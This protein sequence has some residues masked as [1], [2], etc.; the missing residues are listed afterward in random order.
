MKRYNIAEVTIWALA[1]L[2]TLHSTNCLGIEEI[3]NFESQPSI[4]LVTDGNGYHG[5]VEEGD[6]LVNVTPA[7][8]IEKT[9][10]HELLCNILILHDGL[11]DDESPFQVHLLDQVKGTAELHLKAPLNCEEKKSYQ[12]D[13]QA[14]SCTG[15]YSESVGVHVLVEDVNEFAPKWKIRSNEKSSESEP[16]HTLATNVAIEEGQLLEEVIRVEATDEDCS[17]H[18][19]D[20]CG[21][22]IESQNQP[23]TIS[24]EGVIKNTIPLNY[25]VS[26]SYI[27]SVVAFD[28]GQKRSEPLL[29]TVEVKKACSTGWTGLPRLISYVPGT[30]PQ[31]LFGD[32]SL[33]IC[34]KTSCEPE[35][36]EAE[37]TLE[38]S[39][40]GKGCDRDTYNLA[41]QRQLC[42]ASDLAIDLLPD[43][44]HPGSEWASAFLRDQGQ[45]SDS[46]MARFNGETG[47]NIPE[48][49]IASDAFPTHKFTI[50]SWMRHRHNKG[51]DKHTKE[52]ILC[53]ADDH[54]KNRHHLALFVRNCKLVLL[55]R[56][57]YQEG[58]ENTFRPAEWRWRLPQ[59]CDDEWH[60]YAVNVN[61]PVV[62]L[63]VDGEE[64][65]DKKD[66]PEII[67]D[68]P[69]H[70]ADD[71]TTKVT[72]GACW[73]G[74]ENRY[75]HEFS[76]YLA[77]LSYL[78]N[79]VEH[80]EVLRCLHQCAESLQVPAA[81]NALASGTEMTSDA[82]GSRVILTA[83]G[84]G[85]DKLSDLVHQVAYLNTRE[86]P[87]PGKRILQLATTLH[88]R[89]GRTIHLENELMDV[90]V[91]PVPEPVVHISGTSDISREY[92]DFKLGVRIFADVHIV[93]T[94]GSPTGNGEPVNGI[95]NRLDHCSITVSPPLNPDHEAI[96]VPDDLLRQLAVLGKVSADGVE[97]S[98]AEMIYNY[99][100]VLRQVTYSNKKPAYYLNRQ[101]RITCSEL[102][103]RFVSNEY[104]QTLT[105]IHPQLPAV[106][107]ASSAIE[108]SVEMTDKVSKISVQVQPK[109]SHLKMG[110]HG[111]EQPAFS[112]GKNDNFLT[113]GNQQQSNITAM[114]VVV[115]VGL[116]IAF[117]V[118]GIVRL[119]AA[120]NRQTK[121][122]LQAEVEMAWDD[123]ALN[124]TVN[125]I[126][127]AENC[128]KVAMVAEVADLQD[129]YED[130]S[131]EDIMVEDD[132]YQDEDEDD[133]EEE[134]D[135][136]CTRHHPGAGAGGRRA[137]LEW[138]NDI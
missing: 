77:G 5:L 106:A 69:L 10:G 28:C 35:S 30:G 120:H 41:S 82:Q 6:L 121:E 97:F 94:T 130:S 75:R 48:S 89:S 65:T 52:H 86:F 93:M 92:E 85:P 117:L 50:A 56:K 95:E 18:Y 108:P 59:V 125:P 15:A 116:M 34:Q 102:N 39:H 60:H 90:N 131:D 124:I 73:Q 122:E 87:S 16:V 109:S 123:S 4:A 14:L 91:I 22:Q 11:R 100:R 61:F 62:T 136:E 64:W 26:H 51:L 107:S 110:V 71:I 78:A 44:Q 32:A 66:N 128:Q 21:Y 57:E 113:G 13:I 79:A 103:G 137:R 119:R 129:A 42:G 72:I 127:E 134:S 27:L 17:P 43:P 31:A 98:G 138:D 84:S 20:I 81:T 111:V 99:E 36:I 83:D 105:V 96:D 88:C 2:A 74:S 49:L 33:S 29:V 1:A 8:Q 7:I 104:I 63:V 38:T 23:F 45:S 55:L 12:F 115:C 54:R 101:F 24:K 76:G 133:I 132:L 47:V 37:V 3:N 9:D 40:I 118:L 53:K 135:E 67:D 112:L 58:E 68:W 114:I 19:G 25:S 80:T 70:P 126:D 46:S